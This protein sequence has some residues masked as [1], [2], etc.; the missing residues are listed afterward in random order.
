MGF[1]ATRFCV[2]K[3]LSLPLLCPHAL[4]LLWHGVPPGRQFRRQFK[5]FS[6]VDSFH[7]LYFF[8]NFSS[9]GLFHGMQVFRS[10]LIQHVDI[11]TSMDPWW[12]ARVQSAS[13]WS[14]PVPA[15]EFQLW[16]LEPGLFWSLLEFTASDMAAAFG[17]F[18]QNPPLQYPRYHSFATWTQSGGTRR[19][20][21]DGYSPWWKKHR[22]VWDSWNEHMLHF[23]GK[24]FKKPFLKLS[25]F[26]GQHPHFNSETHFSPWLALVETASKC[27]SVASCV[28]FAPYLFFNP[29]ILNTH[30]HKNPTQIKQNKMQL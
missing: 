29:F 7:G 16:G 23:V 9:V 24:A 13:P 30:D 14:L 8:M 15:G 12:T 2:H 22:G 27:I 20:R 21:A 26:I 6:S 11:C 1:V 18:S 4:L 28:Q 17:T 19:S 25:N 3:I 10:R 5:N